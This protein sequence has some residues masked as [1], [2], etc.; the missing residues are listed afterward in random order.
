[1]NCIKIWNEELRVEFSHQKEKYPISTQQK[2][3]R[4]HSLNIF[5]Y[6]STAQL[7]FFLQMIRTQLNYLNK[8]AKNNSGDIIAHC[9]A[10][11]REIKH[12]Q[13]I[14]SNIQ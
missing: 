5:Q 8:T 9:S 11:C 10:S 4:A 14:Q 3:S 2:Y 1:M 12:M 6:I 13:L 7:L